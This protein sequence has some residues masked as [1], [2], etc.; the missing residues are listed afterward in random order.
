MELK[1]NIYGDCASE[2]PTKTYV[3]HRIL[4]KTAKELGALQAESKDAPDEEQIDYTAKMLRCIFPDFKDEDIDGIDLVEIGE[5][6]RGVGA[7]IN[8]VVAKAQKN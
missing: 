8:K 1:I 5:F 2:E 4:F 7:E 6:F 3:A